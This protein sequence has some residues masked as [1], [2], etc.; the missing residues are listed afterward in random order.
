[1]T[2]FI[3]K[4][5]DVRVD[6]NNEIRYKLIGDEVLGM[7]VD[8]F[9]ATTKNVS[10]GG[11]RMVVSHKINEGNVIRVEIPIDN[12]SK[13]IKAFCEVQWCKDNGDGSF[14]LGVSFIALKEDDLE[15]L[16][17]YITTYVT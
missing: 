4:R 9:N 6:F 2:G 10:R 13:Q 7:Q 1:M 11:L 14:D 12:N 17:K 5:A 16:N 3:E 15:F 8:Y